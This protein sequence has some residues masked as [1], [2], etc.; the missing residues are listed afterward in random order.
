MEDENGVVV[1][2][3]WTGKYEIL[4]GDKIRLKHKNGSYISTYFSKENEIYDGYFE[5][6]FV[7]QLK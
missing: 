2:E 3:K 7:R 1:D 6:T 5:V 4:E